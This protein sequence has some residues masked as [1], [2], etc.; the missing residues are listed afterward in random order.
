MITLH[1]LR[2]AEFLK[3]INVAIAWRPSGTC[4][5]HKTSLGSSVLYFLPGFINPKSAVPPDLLD[6]SNSI[7]KCSPYLGEIKNMQ[8]GNFPCA[9]PKVS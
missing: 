5:G 6:L 9:Q 7:Y 4:D 3:A 2:R 8:I 1:L